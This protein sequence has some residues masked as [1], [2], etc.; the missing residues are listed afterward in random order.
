MSL[1]KQV[2][3]AVSGA[4]TSRVVKSWYP[5]MPR[6]PRVLVPVHTDALIVRQV[7]GSWAK[8]RVD[9]QSA[10]PIFENI[11]SPRPKGAYLHWS[12]PDALTRGAPRETGETSEAHFPAIPDRWL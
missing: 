2:A 5:F 6:S 1:N 8:T 7:G 9:G 10:P 3:L 11:P 12:L 4:L